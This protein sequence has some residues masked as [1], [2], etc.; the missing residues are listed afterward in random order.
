MRQRRRW[1]AALL[2]R[3]FPAGMAARKIRQLRT[4]PL[5][6]ELQHIATKI[7]VAAMRYTI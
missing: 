7:S 1:L 3:L 2:D 5:P 4:L 6:L